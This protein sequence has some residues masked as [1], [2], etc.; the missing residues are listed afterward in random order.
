VSVVIVPEITELT[1]PYWDGAREHELRFQRCASC[2]Q[3]WHPP[4]PYCPRCTGRDIAWEAVSGRGIVHSATTVRQAAH[5]AFADKVPYL[6]GLI[7]TDEGPLVIA[8]ILGL[9]PSEIAIG[10]AVTVNFQ[11]ITDQVVLPQ[12]YVVKRRRSLTS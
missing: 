6:V 7:R 12:F 11:A 10:T 5:A 9:D 1:R 3:L 4:L 8:N 2:R